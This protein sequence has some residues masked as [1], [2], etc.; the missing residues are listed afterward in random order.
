MTTETMTTSE[1]GGMKGQKPEQMHHLDPLALMEVAKVAEFGSHKYAAYNYLNGYRWSLS[2][3]AG[4]RHH[5]LHWAGIDRDDESG[6]LHMAHAAWHCLTQISFMIRGLGTDD[7]PKDFKLPPGLTVDLDAEFAKMA[8]TTDEPEVGERF[9][10]KDGD[11]W[12]YDGS[13]E[14]TLILGD[15]TRS[16]PASVFSGRSR[17]LVENDYG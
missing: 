9:K 14:F 8:A 15:G 17:E 6:L 4:Q 3:D 7:R 2:Y 11:L 1:S 5:M 13:D 10:D 16:S 12:E